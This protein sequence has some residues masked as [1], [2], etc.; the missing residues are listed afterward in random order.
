M[1]PYA[2]RLKYQAEYITRISWSISALSDW[3]SLIQALAFLKLTFLRMYV[4]QVSGS[5]VNWG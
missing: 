2:P 1:T 5:L 3:R 4:R